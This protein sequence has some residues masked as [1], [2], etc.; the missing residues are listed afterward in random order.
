MSGFTEV[1]SHTMTFRVL[2]MHQEHSTLTKSTVLVMKETYMT[3][4]IMGKFMLS[5]INIIPWGFSSGLEYTGLMK[6][7]AAN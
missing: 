3:A 6:S 7:L 2:A 5:V 4:V 1:H